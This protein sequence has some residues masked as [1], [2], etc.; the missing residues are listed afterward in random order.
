MAINKQDR[1]EL[2]SLYTTHHE[3]YGGLKEDYFALLYL[4]KKY[5]KTIEEIHTQIAFGGNDYGI[6]AYYFDRDARNLYLYQFKWSE[7]HNLFKESLDRLTDQGISFIFGNSHQ[8]P[9]QNEVIRQLKAD[10]FEFQSVVDRVYIHFIFKGDIESAENSSGLNA[11]KEEL[12]NK[13]YLL[14]QFYGRR[15]TKLIVEF[16]S[17]VRSPSPPPSQDIFEVSLFDHLHT[18]TQNNQRLLYI[19]LVKLSDLHQIY[20]TLGQTFF[21]KNIRAGLSPNNP[22]NRKIRSALTSMI[23]KAEIPPETFVFNHNGVTLAAENIQIHEGRAVLSAPRLLN[24]AQTVSSFAKFLDDNV[25]NLRLKNNEHL[26]DEIRVIAKIVICN[27]N[28]DFIT[29]VT[30]SNNQQNPVDPWNLRAND[31][32]QC[33]FQDKFREDLSMF[34]SRQEN[35]FSNLSE[36][37][38]FDLG[39]EE[40]RDLRIKQL[41]Q[42]FLGVQ[43]EI[44][45]ISRLRDV[46]ESD[47]IYRSTFKESYLKCDCRKIVLTY[48]SLQMMNSPMQILNDKSAEW[49]RYA[50]TRSRNL[51]IALMAQGILNDKRLDYLLDNFSYSLTKEVDYREYLK[52]IASSRI[53]PILRSVYRSDDYRDRIDNGK[54]SFLQTKELYRRCMEVALQ[55]Y[56]WAKKNL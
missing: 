1:Q 3:K 16:I 40:R 19:G 28:D 39:I 7:N 12:E 27:G 4:N 51:V 20:K 56:G 35:S 44:D 25:D 26:I 46:F 23:I 38:L 18:Q 53:L 15:D 24:G 13:R 8:D 37:E 34:Y 6:D 30:M 10:L 45:K 32:I 2:E 50:V 14:E 17:D 29:T 5:N 21:S 55:D 43:G 52:K 42:T 49:M 48:K 54:Y 41:A 33:D 36:E 11:R 9:L 47:K 31:R 22:P